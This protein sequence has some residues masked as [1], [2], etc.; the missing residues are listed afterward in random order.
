[1]EKGLKRIIK[2]RNYGSATQPTGYSHALVQRTTFKSDHMYVRWFFV[3]EVLK[4]GDNKNLGIEVGSKTL[5]E[6]L[7]FVRQGIAAIVEIFHKQQKFS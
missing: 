6:V 1:M 2:N 4:H 7:F 5:K 3:L